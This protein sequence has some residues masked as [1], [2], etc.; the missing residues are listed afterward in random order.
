[1]SN[2][3]PRLAPEDIP[4]TTG[5]ASRFL[6]NVCI[7]KPLID[8]PEPT[9][10]AVAAFGRRKFKTINSQLFLELPFPKMISKI[11]EKGMETEP[12]LILKN[13]NTMRAI[14]SPMN[15]FVYVF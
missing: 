7:N 8:N 10:I 9:K 12:K 6:N 11:S 3:T 4:N 13:I 1:M 14:V 2:A 5:P 15:C